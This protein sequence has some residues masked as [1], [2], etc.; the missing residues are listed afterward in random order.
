MP[1][2]NV[3]VTGATG[4]IARHIIRMLLDDGHHVVGSVRNL[5][6]EAELRGAIGPALADPAALDRLRLVQLDL[7]ADAGWDAAMQGIDVLMHTAS[8]VP[9]GKITVDDSFVTTAIGGT[10]RACKAAYAAGVRRMVVT[11]SM[12]AIMGAD[13]HENGEE[14]DESDWTVPD[15]PHL[16]P[17]TKSK[18]LAERALWDWNQTE[19]PEARITAINPSFVMGP[20]LG[21]TQVPSSLNILARLLSGTDPALPDL[22]LPFVD[23]QDVA[24]MHVLAIDMPQTEGKR[25]LSSENLMSFLELAALLRQDYPDRRIPNRLAPK[26]VMKLIGLFK[27]EVRGIVANWG[28]RDAVSNT[29]AR[30]DMGIEFSDATEAIRASARFLV[31]NDMLDRT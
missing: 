6:A 5:A 2:H 15:R 10:L 30:Q 3:L 7:N 9:N 8:P 1:L 27:V 23:V 26:F 25:Y 19:A 28:R 21:T 14:F 12:A 20:P 13:G 29:R 18:T 16:N 4:Y 17:Y 31:D 11:S 22:S 24:R